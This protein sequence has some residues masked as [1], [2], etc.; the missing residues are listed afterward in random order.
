MFTRRALIATSLIV[1]ATPAFAAAPFR[2]W[3]A[4]IEAQLGGRI[5]A[6]WLGPGGGT[7][8]G[9]R[10]G[11]RFLMCSTFKT[12]LVAATLQSARNNAFS[13]S[14]VVVFADT[15]LVAHSHFLRTRLVDGMGSASREELCEAVIAESDN[16][17]T[18]LLLRDLGGP[19]ALTQFMRRLGDGVTRMDR[20]EWALNYRDTPLD[21]RDTT[22]PL[23]YVRSLRKILF[24]N[25]LA[26]ED[27][28]RL[29]NL[30]RACRNMPNRIRAGVPE[31]WDI[32]VKP[33]TSDTEA[34]AF[35]D[36]GFFKRPG[37]RMQMLAVFL[38]APDA[39]ARACES[40]IAQLAQIVAARV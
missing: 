15:D 4:D 20:T 33:G 19:K 12:F 14:D 17:A 13:L 27:A 18:N 22:T 37:G 38:E 40:A 25:A 34:G 39:G 8:T 2:N 28:R 16:A 1:I 30:M 3:V 26:P 5:G 35:N 29:A 10:Q 11:E 36:V 7:W 21:L 9:Y 23:A 6:A 31:D 32:G 24:G